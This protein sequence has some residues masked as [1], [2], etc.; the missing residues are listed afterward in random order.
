[1]TTTHQEQTANRHIPPKYSLPNTVLLLS[2]YCCFF[3]CPLRYFCR[4]RC[5]D[6]AALL[7]IYNRADA[8]PRHVIC[9]EQILCKIRKVFIENC[10]LGI[11]SESS[12]FLGHMECIFCALLYLILMLVNWNQWFNS[13]TRIFFSVSHGI[14]L[15]RYY[16]LLGICCGANRE[17]FHNRY[18]EPS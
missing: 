4:W 14:F 9:L 3:P 18:C 10:P 6:E 17:F 11:F 1:M 7:F 5:W 8:F 13:F 12:C 2:H 15:C 16:L